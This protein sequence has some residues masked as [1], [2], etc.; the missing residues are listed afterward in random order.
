MKQKTFTHGIGAFQFRYN[1]SM[2]TGFATSCEEE[3]NLPDDGWQDIPGGG[4]KSITEKY[5]DAQYRGQLG[6]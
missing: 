5:A 4:R 6:E 1:D 3:M 2:I